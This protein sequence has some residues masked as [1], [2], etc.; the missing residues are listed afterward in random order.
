MHICFDIG[1]SSIK[2]AIITP[3]NEFLLKKTVPVVDNIQVI[4]QIMNVFVDEAKT[5]FPTEAFVGIAI[6]AP[7]AVDTKTGVIGGA[8]ALESIH[9]PNFKSDLFELT[10]LP[11]AIENDANCAALAELYYGAAKGCQDICTMVIGSGVGGTIVKSQKVHH[12]HNLHGGE[13]GY[14]L[15]HTGEDGIQ[16]LSNVGST[17]ALVEHAQKIDATIENGEQVFELAKTDERFQAVVDSFYF[18]VAL[19]AINVQYTYDPECIVF[20]GAVSKQ[21]DFIQRVQEHIQAI[22][23][24]PGM[25]H[26]IVPTCVTCHFYN[27]ANLLGAKVNF[28]QQ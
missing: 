8:S 21:V 7:G 5:A 11:V 20:G 14:M 26:T 15:V 1:G 3:E 16:S 24:R 6:S 13:F 19:G 12:G 17:R 23:K 2:M 10:H 9:G 28:S 22:I 4:Y 25:S 18:Y 27:D